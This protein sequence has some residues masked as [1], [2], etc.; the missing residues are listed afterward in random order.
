MIDPLPAS[1]LTVFSNSELE[2]LEQTAF[3]SSLIGMYLN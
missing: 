2:F 3:S 1:W